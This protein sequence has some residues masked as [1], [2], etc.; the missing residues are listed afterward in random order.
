MV[1]VESLIDVHGASLTF[2]GVQHWV[3][4]VDGNPSGRYEARPQGLL[5][6]LR[7]DDGNVIDNATNQWFDWLNEEK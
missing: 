4:Y 5:G 3:F 7:S 6:S 1:E 2:Q